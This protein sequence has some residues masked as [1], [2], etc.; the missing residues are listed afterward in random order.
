MSLFLN[1]EY[2][3]IFK[4]T[5]FEEHPQWLLPKMCSWNWQKT[6]IVHKEFSTLYSRN[7]WKCL[8][9]FHEKTSENSCFY[10]MAGFLWI[11]Y[12]VI[13][14]EINSK[15]SRSTWVNQKKIKSSWNEY[16]LWT[17]LNNEK[18]FPKTISQCLIIAC[19]QICRELLS[20]VT[21]V[22][23]SSFKL[24]RGILTLLTKYVS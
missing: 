24:R 3:K 8:F 22:T 10:F 4:S 5:H 13:W 19:L 17:W 14:W 18:Q 2:C 7:K 6:K 21:F 16:V 20:L 9:L 15:Q 12:S 1:L 23:Q 11:L